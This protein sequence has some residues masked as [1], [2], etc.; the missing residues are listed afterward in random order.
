METI[1]A[2]L[3]VGAISLCILPIVGMQV[4]L[5]IRLVRAPYMRETNIQNFT[6]DQIADKMIEKLREEEKRKNEHDN[7]GK[8]K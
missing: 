4:I 8:T 3:I 2:V 7:A 5:F 6:L 1:Y